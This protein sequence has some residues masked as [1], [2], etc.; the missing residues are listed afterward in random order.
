MLHWWTSPKFQWFATTKVY[1]LYTLYVCCQQRTVLYCS[2]HPSG[3]QGNKDS[4]IYNLQPASQDKSSEFSAGGVEKARSK[5]PS[6][7]CFSLVMTHVTSAYISLGRTCHRI[8]PNFTKFWNHNPVYQEAD[9]K[10]IWMNI[11]HVHHTCLS[12][13]CQHQMSFPGKVIG[14]PA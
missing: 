12:G 4:L 2:T 9:K 8:L 7:K 10:W 3:T 14:E 11:S 5:A 1:F 13:C 6:V